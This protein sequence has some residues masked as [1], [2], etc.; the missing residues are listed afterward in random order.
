MKSEPPEI[1]RIK[2]IHQ[3][4]KNWENEG[5]KVKA[6]IGGWDRP[7]EVEGLIPDLTGVRGDDIRIGCVELEEDAVIDKARWDK[8]TA[9]YAKNKN[10]SLRLYS[11]SKDGVCSLKKIIP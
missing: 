11:L 2:S 8:L 5:F 1:L 6:N 4:A 7:S 10:A 3:R 9:Y